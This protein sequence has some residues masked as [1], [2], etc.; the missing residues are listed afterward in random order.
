MAM[1][2]N[3]IKRRMD[4]AWESHFKEFDSEAEWYGIEDPHLWVCDIPSKNITV[5]MELNEEYLDIVISV[6]DLKKQN[7]YRYVREA[8]WQVVEH[9]SW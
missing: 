3:Q 1:T 8:D 6:T 5:K 2:E 4:E 7:D 9:Y